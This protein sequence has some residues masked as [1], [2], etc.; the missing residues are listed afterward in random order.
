[1]RRVAGAA[2]RTKDGLVGSWKA[3][4]TH[5]RHCRDAARSTL[6]SPPRL[7]PR[8]HGS[9]T[10]EA[11]LSLGSPAATFPTFSVFLSLT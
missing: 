5:S 9:K 3:G 6:A 1:M 2:L 7:R 10:S 4:L 11:A 8:G